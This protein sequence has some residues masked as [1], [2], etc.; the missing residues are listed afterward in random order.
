ME[1]ADIVTL[2]ANAGGTPEFTLEGMWNQMG[3]LAKIVMIMLLL[4]FVFGSKYF[5][6]F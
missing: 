2:L 5:L 3:I 6:F 1:F 4:M